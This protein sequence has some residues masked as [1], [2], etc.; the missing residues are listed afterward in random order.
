MPADVIERVHTLARRSGAAVGM[1]FTD[2]S[3]TP[4]ADDDDSD[5]ESYDPDDDPDDDDD[6][7][8]DEPLADEIPIEGVDLNNENGPNE[9][10]ET[11]EGAQEPEVNENVI[12][13]N[14]NNENVTVNEDINENEINENVPVNEDTN[15]INGNEDEDKAPEEEEDAG[16]NVAAPAPMV[17][18]VDD[19]D[20]EDNGETNRNMD[21]KYCERSGTHNLR[22]RKPRDY[23][24]LHATLESITMTQHLMKKG[25]KKFGDAGTDAVLKELKQ[26]HALKAL[27]PAEEICH[28]HKRKAMQYLSVPKKKCNVITK[29]C[30]LDTSAA[31]D[32][33]L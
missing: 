16:I 23:S 30:L 21:D 18:T 13:I 25:I 15:E 22:A 8:D 6:D 33:L 11:M 7:G 5:D 24:H 31:A 17:E 9:F 19:G 4:Y 29:R 14:E 3:G 12:D 27:E 10:N 1:Q 26:L 2:R 28:Q 32:D 20:G